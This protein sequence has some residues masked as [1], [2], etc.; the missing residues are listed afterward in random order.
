MCGSIYIYINTEVFPSPSGRYA[1]DS[2]KRNGRSIRSPL[3]VTWVGTKADV[4]FFGQ[5]ASVRPSGINKRA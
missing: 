1:I 5:G 4:L 2:S 3:G